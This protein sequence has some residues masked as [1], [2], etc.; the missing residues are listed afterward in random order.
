M[1]LKAKLNKMR[2]QSRKTRKG[3]KGKKSTKKRVDITCKPK[4][5][6]KP[7][8][9]DGKEWYWCCKEKGGKYSGVLCRHKPSECKGIFKSCSIIQFHDL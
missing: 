6:H 5:I 7:V 9:I 1:A 2:K 4:D 8:V 3:G